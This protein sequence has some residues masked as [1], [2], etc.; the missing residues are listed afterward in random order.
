[1]AALTGYSG[2]DYRQRSPHDL[3]TDNVRFVLKNV[4]FSTPIFIN[5]HRLRTH[6]DEHTSG[7]KFQSGRRRKRKNAR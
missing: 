1:M 4:F 6:D 3:V 7:A 2:S 5:R